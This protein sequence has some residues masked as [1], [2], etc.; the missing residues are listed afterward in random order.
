VE[1]KKQSFGTVKWF[2]KEKGWGFISC[3]GKDHFVHHSDI[4]GNGFK[5]LISGQNVKFNQEP[6]KKGMLAKNVS[7]VID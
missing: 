2:D 3:N 1:D 7:I 6:S 5:L 4:I